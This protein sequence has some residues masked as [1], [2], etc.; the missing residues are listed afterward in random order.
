MSATAIILIVISAG[1]HAGWNYVGKSN[2]PSAAAFLGATALSTMCLLPILVYHHAQVTAVLP[3]IWRLLIATGFA[4]GAYF[5]GLGTA[6]RFG[7]M[8]IAY[9]LAR[10]SPIIVVTVVS[11]F[12]GRGDQ[13]STACLVGAVLVVG[14]CFLLPM[15][16]F[17]DFR[18]GNYANLCCLMALLAAV[19]TAGYSI[20]DDETLR[21]MR[22][23]GLTT[24]T[25]PMIYVVLQG[26]STSLWMTPVVLL[27]RTERR[28]MAT[29]LRGA[30]GRAWMMGM[31]IHLTYGLVLASMLFAKNISYVVAFRQMSIPIGAVLGIVLLKEPHPMPK[32]IGLATIV[33]GLV[34][35]A[36]G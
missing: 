25:A 7:D 36:I 8:S 32:L 30:K 12:L 14:G 13:I 15:A 17:T 28:E 34:L 26:V 23:G 18:W 2:R 27:H 35:V 6:Y 22:D 9:P 4:Q 24:V 33:T 31:T 21:R 3:D 10:S 5:V 16:R 1:M 19:G 20:I 29:V 11:L